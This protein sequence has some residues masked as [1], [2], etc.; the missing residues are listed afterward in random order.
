VCVVSAIDR[1]LEPGEDDLSF[2]PG[3][4]NRCM[5]FFQIGSVDRAHIF[6]QCGADAALVDHFRVFTRPKYQTPG[7]RAQHD[8]QSSLAPT[9]ATR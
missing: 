3:A 4:F 8:L 9:H 1:Q 5:N 6:A 7:M 2:G